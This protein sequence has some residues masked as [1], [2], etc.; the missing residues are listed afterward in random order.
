MVDPTT[1]PAATTRD[2]F[3]DSLG[4]VNTVEP[5]AEG[6]MVLRGYAAADTPVLLQS[7]G[8][9]LAVAPFRHMVTPGGFRM[10]VA[11]TNCGFAGWVSDRTGYRY[12]AVDPD[13]GR[14][15][16]PMPASFLRLATSAAEQAGFPGFE[17]DACLVNRYEPGARLSLHQ[18]KDERDFTAPIV[19]VSL[20]LPAVFL[21]GGNR[22]ADRPGRLRLENGDVAVWGG[23]ARLTYHGIAPLA[24]GDDPH[25]GRCRIN[26]TFRKAL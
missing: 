14:R 8:E 5:L 20:G 24:S 19:S 13:S 2:L 22:R 6:A 7:L 10:S 4:P 26:L 11:M 21:F 3:G 18:D 9:I 17:P 25:T 15:W 16:P 1:R 23:P 12:D